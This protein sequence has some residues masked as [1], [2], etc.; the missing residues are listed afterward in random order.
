MYRNF[1][2]ALAALLVAVAPVWNYSRAWTFGP[3]IAVLFLLSVNL[4]VYLFAQ[5]EPSES[6]LTQRSA[7]S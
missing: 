7:K 1:I 2:L 5:H 3:F 6:R 4:V